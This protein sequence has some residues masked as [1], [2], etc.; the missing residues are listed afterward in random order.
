MQPRVRNL[1]LGLL[2]VALAAGLAF[3]SLNFGLP[4]LF[5]PDEDV[6]VGRAVRMA[7]EGSLD[8]LF[9]NYPPLV[10]YVFAAAERL[11]GQLGGAVGHDPSGAY[12]AAR[13]V[14]A[15]ASVLT[16]GLVFE[17]GRRAY[18]AGAGLGA[19]LAL[20]VA[21]LA[22][23]QAHFATTDAVQA[24][25][26]AAALLAGLSARGR[27]GFLLA[28]A[29]CGLAA[30]SKYTGGVVLVYV[31]VL[32][33]RRFALPAV[34]GAAF[35]FAL[36]SLAM[37]LHPAAYVGGL[38]FLGGNAYLRSHNLPIGW[39][40][41]STVTLPFGLGL[42]AFAL[43]LAGIA[44]A[45]V[46]RLRVDMALLAFVAAYF[47]LTGAGHE[48][49]FRYMLPLLPALCLLAGGLLRHA[50]AWAAVAFGLLLLPSLYAS[51]ETDRLLGTTDTRVLAASWLEANLPV[52]AAVESPYYGG[53]FY[54]AA[55]VAQ[56]RRFVDDPLAAGFLQGRFTDR[57]TIGREPAA[58]TLAASGPPWQ[59][60]V[61]DPAATVSFSAGRPGAVY[62]QL[63]SF[64]VPIW[65][66]DLVER[67][68]PS[69][70]IIR[71]Q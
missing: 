71:R 30:A 14:T 1:A 17:A 52:G 50:P 8:P 20:A 10:F 48:D 23:R 46:H 3:W 21:P 12:L 4:F 24:A 35:A 2:P 42:G 29:L 69:I 53:P 51:V 18:G 9:A 70:S 60:P 47:A 16:V 49:F 64:Y 26:V 6:M 43:A 22:V 7:A 45:G 68:G 44:W 34:A 55:Q 39:I 59:A 37:L 38:A 36:P 41:H 31:L 13:T 63:D 15:A 57:F 27:R 66:F 33:G 62:D 5:R 40:Y 56:N 32:A 11:T 65:G 25:F 67:P 58:A 19:A 54:D 61:P 28:G